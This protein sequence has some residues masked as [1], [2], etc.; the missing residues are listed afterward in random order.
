[1]PT[2][3]GFNRRWPYPNHESTTPTPLQETHEVHTETAAVTHQVKADDLETFDLR[4]V[5]LC[6]TGLVCRSPCRELLPAPMPGWMHDL[7]NTFL[8][9][10][11]NKMQELCTSAAPH[12]FGEVVRSWVDDCDTPVVSHAAVVHAYASCSLPL[13]TSL[14]GTFGWCRILWVIE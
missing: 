1:M 11:S 2:P 14:L 9:H 4:Q 8:L 5:G 12:S 6:E 10:C 13:P 7:V 3:G